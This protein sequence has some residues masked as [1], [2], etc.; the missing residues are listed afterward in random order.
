[1]VA[2]VPA[3]ASDDERGLLLRFIAEG[4]AGLRRSVL[5][6][7]DE[8][9]GERATASEL[10]LSGLVKHVAEVEQGWIARAKGVDPA[11]ARSQENWDECFRL[12]GEETVAGQLAYWEKV[13]AETEAYVLGLDGIEV[14]VP[15]PDEPWYPKEDISVRWIL[16][17][18]IR[19]INR[20]AGHADIIR[21]SID[22]KTAWGL[23]AEESG[24]NWG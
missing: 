12:V 5:G 9:A 14:T 18:L 2:H 16:L 6:L 21:E 22:G 10:T 4:R 11:V 23:M 20:H 7:S 24:E 15:L 17:H 19:E 13:A 8:R 1:M 3:G